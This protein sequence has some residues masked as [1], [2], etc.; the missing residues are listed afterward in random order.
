M[1]N[2]TQSI[3]GKTLFITIIL[4]VISNVSIGFLGY[5]IAKD[6]LNEKGETILQNAVEMSL[7]MIDLAN[8]EVEN[9]TMELDEAQEMVKEYLL[10]ER[11]ADGT[12]PITAPFDLGENGYIVVYGQDGEEIAHPTLEGENVWDVED[13]AGNGNLLV[14]D[15]IATANIGG[16]FTYYD[17]F[18][19]DSEDIG[20]KIV[21]NELDPNWGWIVTAG[22]YESDYNQGAFTVLQY[23]S[24]SI[25]AFL[26]I[27]IAIMYTFSNSLGKALGSVTTSADRLSNLDVTEDIPVKLTKRKDEIGLLALSFQQINDNLKDF[28]EKIA[29]TSTQLASSSKELNISSEQ[30]SLAANEVAGAIEEIAKG[31]AEQAMDTENGSKRIEELGVLVES[32][33]NYLKNLNTST[34]KVDALKNEGSTS[35]KELLEATETSSRS[36]ADI[37]DIIVSTNE[38]AQRIGNAS[39]MIKN[40]AEQTNLLA[41]NAAIEAARAGD[42]GKGFAVVAEEIRKLADQS[43]GFTEEISGIVTD[44]NANTTQAVETMKELTAISEHQSNKVE[45]TNTKFNGISEAITEMNAVIA[46]LNDSGEKMTEKKEKII[47]VIENLSAI[48]EENAAGTEEASAS[49]EEQTSTMLEIANAS[50]MLAE[51]AGEMKDAIAKF[52]Y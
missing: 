45:Q 33:E 23:T 19:P 15:S 37:Q 24:I 48:S 41:L 35:L 42:A 20:T 27:A 31:A 36:T 3:K 25:L 10:G 40:I 2:I 47:E 7:Q 1:S 21:Y 8:Q 44:L 17:W 51:L 11:Q 16:G 29:D 26:V 13:K 6:Q 9:G 43:N 12:R 30:S 28:V 5:T 14:Q 39:N 32:N 49:V 34:H 4:L 50:E 38:S 22:S 18:Y 52:N 46:S